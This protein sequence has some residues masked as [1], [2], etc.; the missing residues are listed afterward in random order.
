MSTWVN[1]V[2]VLFSL[3]CYIDSETSKFAN[4]LKIHE[5]LKHDFTND[6]STL[7]FITW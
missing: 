4:T 5:M 1:K 6:L 3:E 2:T 7:R